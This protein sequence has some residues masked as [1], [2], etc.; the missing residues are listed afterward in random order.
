MEKKTLTNKSAS[1]RKQAEKALQDQA[2]DLP[3][4][5]LTSFGD[6]QDRRSGQALDELSPEEVKHLVHELRV[7]Q[8]ELEMQNG[9]LRRAQQ[10]LEAS[11]DRYAELYDFAPVGYLTL[12]E[13]G[14]ILQANLTISSLL[15]VARG[16]LIK[17]PLSRFIASED[18]DIYYLHRKALFETQEPQVCELRMERKNGIQFWVRVEAT[19]AQD[20]EGL[21]ICRATVSD[22]NAQKRME[23][24]RR[25]SA[26]RLRALTETSSDHILLLDT[27]LNI[28]FA[29]FASPGLTVEELV[30]TPIYAYVQEERQAEIK[31]ILEGV[32]KTGET[33][34]YETAYDIHDGS[35]IYYESRVTPYK[36][37]K[38]DA[39]DS[40]NDIT[41]LT[42]N[43]RN[44]TERKR[45]EEQIKAALEER[46]VL[47]R[48]VHHRVK[49]N[50]QTLIHLIDMQMETIQDPTVAHILEDFQGRVNA[51]GIVHEQL[52]QA[53]DL[54]QINFGAY[55]EDL[56]H[57]L[58]HALAGDQPIALSVVAE[59]V[60]ISVNKALPCGMIVNELMTNALKYAFPPPLSSPPLGGREHEIRVEFGAHEDAYV[61]TVGDNGVGLP[62][63]LDWHATESLGLK[64]V[65]IWATYQLAGTLDVNTRDGTI[66]A[67]KFPK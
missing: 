5:P 13:T 62:P 36:L 32:L 52:Y 42:L 59:D 57:Q 43:A 11:R 12:N 49:N 25:Q 16:D 18:E 17:Q 3:E 23:E 38:G 6:A 1:L 34:S 60:P 48:E 58:Y 46:E 21:P 4:N 14:T 2:V 33:A 63:A 28:Q 55:L 56:T 41:G 30:G 8:I 67:I 7:H 65:N 50:M 53:K 20:S 35:T 10:E 24:D 37:P 31:A 27:N 66:F 39:P 45:A 40:V 29:N 19:M 26:V 54:G 9:E 61:L 47:L 22:V 15:G 64:L 51:M 44:I